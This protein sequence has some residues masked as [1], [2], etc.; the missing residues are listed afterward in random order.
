MGYMEEFKKEIVNLSTAG[1]YAAAVKEWTF[2]GESFK[3]HGY[4]LCGHGIA[5]NLIVHN[6][7]GRTATVG[8]CCIKKFGIERKHYNKSREAYLKLALSKAKPGP[9][10]AFIKELFHKLYT[11][12]QL[13]M[14]PAQYEW[15][16]KIAG[17]PY[18][19]DWK[20]Y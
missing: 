5:E 9:Q 4:C 1:T 19:W 8:N 7:N 16:I 6:D 20:W 13:R 17:V 12:D 10:E 15:M 14:T 2:R 18:R 11:Y 3:K